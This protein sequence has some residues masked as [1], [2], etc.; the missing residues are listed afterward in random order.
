MSDDELQGNPEYSTPF[1]SPVG[2][3][4]DRE[5]LRLDDSYVTG[6]FHHKPP[7]VGDLPPVLYLHG[8]QSHPGWFFASAGQLAANGHEV[9]QVAR[10]GSGA[11]HGDR[12][13]ARSA[14]QTLDDVQA[15]IRFVLERT[16]SR[17]VALVG[18]SWGGKLAAAFC[19]S[20]DAEAIASLTLVAPGMV[21]LI[22]V[23]PVTKLAIA[24]CLLVR[25]RARFDIPLGAPELFTDNESMQEFIRTDRL[26]LHCATARFMY[27]SR[28]LD[29]LIGRAPA[30]CLKM[31]VTLILSAHDRIIDS[32]ATARSI[33][34]LTAERAEIIS[35]SGAH[36]LEFQEDPVAFY[37]A[38]LTAC[39]K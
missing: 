24:A 39:E 36:T 22:D 29:R 12:G 37:Q 5:E 33:I 8:I 26:A 27:A 1:A 32:V 23:S 10:R 25:P 9:F 30:G 20:S 16:G 18:V 38:L 2:G 34:R 31:P 15:A 14:R 13:H 21:P 17:R 11:N 7:S 6:L 28:C 19:A 3:W 35:L 4:P